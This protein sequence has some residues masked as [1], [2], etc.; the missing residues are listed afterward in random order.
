[1]DCENV[2]SVVLAQVRDTPLPNMVFIVIKYL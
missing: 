2:E 1:M